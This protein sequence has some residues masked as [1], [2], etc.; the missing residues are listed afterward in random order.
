MWVFLGF[1]RLVAVPKIAQKRF[2]QQKSLQ[3]PYTLSWDDDTFTLQSETGISNTPWTDF[4]MWRESEN[5]F[6]VYFTRGLFRII[7][8]RFFGEPDS[9]SKFGQLLHEKIG[10]RS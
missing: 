4:L 2:K 8:K 9:A 5:L 1:L 10:A 6:V 3:R 7:P